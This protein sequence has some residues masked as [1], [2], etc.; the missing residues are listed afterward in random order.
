[1]DRYVPCVTF[2]TETKHLVD[3]F[4]QRRC[5]HTPVSHKEEKEV[6]G[7]ERKVDKMEMSFC[8]SL[9]LS[10]NEDIM[11]VQNTRLFV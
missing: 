11:G 10:D 2:V 5:V 1:M 9:G 3:G 4:M 7:E 8:D 6:R